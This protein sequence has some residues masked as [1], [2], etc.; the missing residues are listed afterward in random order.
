MELKNPN[1]NP[2]ANWRKVKDKLKGDGYSEA[3]SILGPDHAK[4]GDVEYKPEDFKINS[5]NRFLDKDSFLSEN[6]GEFVPKLLLA[7]EAQ[8]GEKY[9]LEYLFKAPYQDTVMEFMAK[10][11]RADENQRLFQ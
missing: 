9:L 2:Y 10:V 1:K 4:S 7:M 3:I 8:D 6:E 11:D 5:V